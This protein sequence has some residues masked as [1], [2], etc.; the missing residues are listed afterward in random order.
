MTELQLMDI[1]Q[2]EGWT[3]SKIESGEKQI[4][5]AGR[6]QNGKGQTRY[7]ERAQRNGTHQAT[8]SDALRD[9]HV[10]TSKHFYLK[11]ERDEKDI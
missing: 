6:F 10:E 4:F 11:E 8:R 3:I 7:K 9:T 5:R 1:L 2:T